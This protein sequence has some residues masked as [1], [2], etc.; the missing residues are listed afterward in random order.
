GV[1]GHP[2]VLGAVAK[3]ARRGAAH[4]P[5][6]RQRLRRVRESRTCSR[7]VH[8]LT[9]HQRTCHE[10]VATEATMSCPSSGHRNALWRALQ[11]SRLLDQRQEVRLFQDE[12]ARAVALQRA[13][14]SGTVR[15]AYRRAG[16]KACPLSRT[17]WLDYH[18]ERLRLS[19]GLPR[20]TRSLVVSAGVGTVDQAPATCRSRGVSN[21]TNATRRPA[22]STFT[23]PGCNCH[24]DSAVPFNRFIRGPMRRNWTIIGVADVARSCTWYQSL[25]GLP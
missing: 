22:P 5:A 16:C 21:S 24:D 20:G 9:H 17:V 2:G 8:R 11:L 1:G 14:H 3:A 15:R 12:P 7:P 13:R 10:R 23:S 6:I 4:A 19:R 25:L 18:R